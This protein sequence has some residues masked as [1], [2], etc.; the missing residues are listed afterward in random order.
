MYRKFCQR[1]PVQPVF[2]L[3]YIADGY[4]DADRQYDIHEYEDEAA[5]NIFLLQHDQIYKYNGAQDDKEQ[6]D[7]QK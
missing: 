5:H 6:R 2:E 3:D 7:F 4:Y 1:P